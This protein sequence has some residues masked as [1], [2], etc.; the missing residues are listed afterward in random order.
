M[1]DGVVMGVVQASEVGLLEGQLRLPKIEPDLSLRRA[2]ET[3]DF[4]CGDGK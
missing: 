3:I 2:V 4:G 1:L